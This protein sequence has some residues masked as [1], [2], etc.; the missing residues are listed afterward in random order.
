MLQGRSDHP[1]RHE[2]WVALDPEENRQ[3]RKYKYQTREKAL[4]ARKQRK[5]RAHGERRHR[6]KMHLM[7]AGEDGRQGGT[8]SQK[9]DTKRYLTSAK[10]TPVTPI[11]AKCAPSETT[12]EMVPSFKQADM[13]GVAC[14]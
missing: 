14:D 2:P 8:R 7:A 4:A 11:L 6:A 12:E 3:N 5:N 9:T 13:G 10:T 1:G